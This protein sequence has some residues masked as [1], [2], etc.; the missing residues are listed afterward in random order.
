MAAELRNKALRGLGWTL[1]VLATLILALVVVLS[2]PDWLRR[3]LAKALGAHLHRKIEI[4]GP[5]VVHWSSAPV[6]SVGRITVGNPAWDPAHPMLTLQKLQATVR[7]WPLLR[8]RVVVPDIDLDRPILLL[9]RAADGRA[10]WSFRTNGHGAPTPGNTY[11]LG[12]L[13]IHEGQLTFIEP[14]GAIAVHAALATTASGRHILARGTGRFRNKP[15]AFTFQGGSVLSLA[16]ARHPY[17]MTLSAHIG[18]THGQAQ[19]TITGLPAL[20]RLRLRFAIAGTDL[21]TLYP[22]FGIP[23]PHTA[24]FSLRGRLRR[25]GPTWHLSQFHGAV[26]HS[27]LGGSLNISTQPHFSIRGTLHSNRLALKD[28]AGF[29]GAKPQT[30]GHAERVAT[31]A[32]GAHRVLPNSKFHNRKLASSNMDIEYHAVHFVSG[33]FPLQNLST[34]VRLQHGTLQFN[35]L[36]FGLADGHVESQV[37]VTPGHPLGLRV[38]ATLRGLRLAKL[39]PKLKFPQT[40]TGRVGGKIVLTSEGTTFAA[41][42]SH[43]TG[44]VG[45]AMAGGSVSNVLVALAQLHFGNALAHWIAGARKENIRCAVARLDMTH[46]LMRTKTF[47]IDTASTNIFGSGTINFGDE[48][49]HLLLRTQPKHISLISTRGPL[50]ISGTFKKPAFKVDRKKIL[51][52]GAAAAAL[53]TITPL[54]ALLPLVDT[55]PGHH[56]NCGILLK[57]AGAGTRRAALGSR[58]PDSK[59]SAISGHAAAKSRQQH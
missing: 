1:G 24:R 5:L 12:H 17:P 39:F 58:A 54:A 41:F 56:L 33:T 8:G 31:P 38:H 25:H 48:Q 20:G 22:I 37:G 55:A 53:A 45:A 35:P 19:G 32:K 30:Q 27:D 7:L 47:V 4:A 6:V 23:L 9:E 11:S 44:H 14:K 46:G 57:K 43:A 2:H 10:N 15:F 36:D 21:S 26:G 42:A 40:N 3:P 13:D 59:K 34:H 16:F 51:E 49:M 50:H 18:A 29:T 52:R 28:L